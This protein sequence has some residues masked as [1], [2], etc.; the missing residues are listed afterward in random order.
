MSTDNDEKLNVFLK[1]LTKDI[2]LEKPHDDFTD[3]VLRTIKLAAS[4]SDRAVYTPVFSRASWIVIVLMACTL[5]FLGYDFGVRE[6]LVPGYISS[7][8]EYSGSLL[9]GHLPAIA[10]SNILVFSFLALISALAIQI[11]WLKKSWAKKQVLF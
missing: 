6:T 9:N 11:V 3:N 10:S 7:L 5:L 1:E 4:T 8:S 2:P